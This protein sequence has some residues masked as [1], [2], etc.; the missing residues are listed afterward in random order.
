M[1]WYNKW[2]NKIEA[3]FE[4]GLLKFGTFIE[5]A[6]KVSEKLFTK[7]GFVGTL[8]LLMLLTLIGEWTS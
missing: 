5:K 7:E 6:N 4:T 2:Y 8:S 1:K 3:K